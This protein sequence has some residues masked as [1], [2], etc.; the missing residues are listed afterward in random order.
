MSK[1]TSCNIKSA[2][3]P[4]VL[5]VRR[6]LPNLIREPLNA[7]LGFGTQANGDIVRLNLGT[8]R[9]YL[10][11]HPAHVQHML[12]DN[13]AN[14]ERAGD[15]LFWKPV[16]RLFGEGI[17]GEGR[18]WSASRKMLQPLFTAK[19]VEALVDRMAEEIG[20]AVAELDDSSRLG[21]SIDLKHTL[22]TIVCRTMMKVLFADKISLPDAMRVVNAQDAIA[23][24][25]LPRILV[26][27]APL[28]LP[29]PGDR[30]FRE[31]VRTVDE[32]IV[33]I[34]RRH[35]S[36][37]D[38]NGDDII[39]TLCRARTEDGQLLD[40]QQIRNDTVA[41]FAATTETTINLLTWLW[42]H[43][44]ARPD[45]ADR[46]RT[47]I[48]QVV[49]TNQVR[50]EHLPELTYTKMVLDELLRL[51][52][53]G[54]L[55]PRRAVGA[56]AVGGVRIEAGATIV[57]SP[58][59]TQRLER[60]WERPH[61]F[62]PDRFTP[63]KVRQ[64]HRYAHFPFGGGPHQCLGMYLFY[65]EAQL[66]VAT[67]LSRFQF[68]MNTPKIPTPRIAASLRPRDQVNMTLLPV[69]RAA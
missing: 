35:R 61:H 36:R 54:W 25:V 19:R 65:L 10:V 53:I 32:V 47:E 16:R 52:P 15:G 3:D 7:L 46:L 14:Y 45:V 9:P 20:A 50:R 39:S 4:R 13:S 29:M 38:D 58:L 66:I 62:D 51:Y 59:V 48:N 22:S 1:P 8:F 12:R 44:N 23:T 64:R 33:P 26:P 28:A 43:L 34:I 30:T 21:R 40:E 42:P 27:F 69:Q 24:A 60:F 5:P 6:A 37:P 63:D 11:T 56:D 41:M 67:V 55:I 17:L 49:G 2:T 31:A 57:I 68:R 18:I